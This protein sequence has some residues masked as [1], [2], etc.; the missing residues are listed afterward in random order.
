MSATK[1]NKYTKR[2]C[3]NLS[4]YT[5]VRTTFNCFHF[6]YHNFVSEIISAEGNATRLFL[7]ET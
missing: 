5:C 3:L 7:S 1:S 4:R 2:I 6:K